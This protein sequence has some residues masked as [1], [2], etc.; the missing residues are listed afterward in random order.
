ML[1]ERV[2]QG[3]RAER[4]RVQLDHGAAARS[5]VVPQHARARGPVHAGLDRHGDAPVA[6]VEQ[7]VRVDPPAV[8]LRWRE[9]RDPLRRLLGET[10]EHRRRT[11]ERPPR[12]GLGGDG[13]R[14]DAVVLP[15]HAGHP[16]TRQLRDG[17]RGPLRIGGGVS[18]HQLQRP[19]T[20]AAGL[21]DVPNG[22]LGPG[23]HAPPGLHP[24][25]RRQRHE[26]TDPHCSVGD[27][28]LRARGWWWRRR[29]VH[30][31][32]FPRADGWAATSMVDLGAGGRQRPYRRVATPHPLPSAGAI[33]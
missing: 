3:R 10:V 17:R 32:V 2:T 20:D 8:R 5:E 31:L 33:V 18:H 11:Q 6:R 29:R 15:D 12:V 1:D 24:A 22:H 14:Y 16:E 27:G 26:D 21:V 30:V 23:Q 13:P 9:P 25:G 28:A 4:P 7:R 19:P